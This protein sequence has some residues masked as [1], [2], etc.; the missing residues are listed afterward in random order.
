[1]GR[2]GAHLAGLSPGHV[3]SLAERAGLG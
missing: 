3:A 1:L 2:G